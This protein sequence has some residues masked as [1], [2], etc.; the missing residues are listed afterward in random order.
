MTGPIERE[1]L[2]ALI[3]SHQDNL[4]SHHWLMTTQAAHDLTLTIQ[5]L[6]HYRDLTDIIDQRQPD[7]DPFTPPPSL[8]P[9]VS[10]ETTGATQ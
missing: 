6:T 5:I 3:K 1:D 8:P 9:P 7:P 2:N 10:Q 4:W